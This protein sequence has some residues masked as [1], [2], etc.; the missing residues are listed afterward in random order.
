MNLSKLSKYLWVIFIIIGLFFQIKDYGWLY[1]T[2][3]YI[4]IIGL[5]ALFL[6]IVINL[7][8]LIK[9]FHKIWLIKFLQITGFSLLYLSLFFAKH[10]PDFISSFLIN[11]SVMMITVSI[12]IRYKYIKKQRTYS[13]EARIKNDL[14]II[15]PTHIKKF[16]KFLSWIGGFVMPSLPFFLVLNK[17]W[18]KK[19]GKEA[20]IH[21]H[22][23]L[24]YLQNGVFLFYLVFVVG[25]LLLINIWFDS[26]LV[27]YS[28]LIV[29]AVSS[30]TFFEYIT[31]RKTNEYGKKL[32]IRTRRWNNK[33]C[34]KYLY[35]YLIQITI[36][37][38]VYLGV[39]YLFKYLIK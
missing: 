3:K 15:S 24:Y 6:Y 19:L 8:P 23:H 31:F 28:A 1:G 12:Y 7:L 26:K 17:K 30:F 14:K 34:F 20:M 32:G 37:T 38:L 4:L 33:I 18:K 35:V 16:P 39:K 13:L 25:S 5:L 10:L 22:V 29:L 11:I 36:V 9:P 2:I 21:E 27:E